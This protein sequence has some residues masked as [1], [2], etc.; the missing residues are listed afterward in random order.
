[1]G[2]KINTVDLMNNDLMNK[3]EFLER[4]S[5]KTHFLEMIF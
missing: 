4:I 3:R 2:L 5:Q 1:M